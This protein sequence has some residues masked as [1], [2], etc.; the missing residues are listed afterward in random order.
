MVNRLFWSRV[1]LSLQV[2]GA[3]VGAV[4]AVEFEDFPSTAC[5]SVYVYY[6]E[7]KDSQDYKLFEVI[8]PSQFGGEWIFV[9]GQPDEDKFKT[10][11]EIN[12]TS[13]LKRFKFGNDY[14]KYC[15]EFQEEIPVGAQG[16]L[17]KSIGA[18]S[19]VELVK[20]Y[21]SALYKFG[22][23]FIGLICVLVI[24]VSGIQMS[25]GGL[26]SSAFESAKNRILAAILSLVLLFS[27]AMILRTINPGFFT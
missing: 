14:K 25:I 26:D 22:S 23:I 2:F 7:A 27:S 17:S 20:N 18:D 24:V 13:V 10:D 1:L 3:F 15:V 19:G 5:E 8:K 6:F 9:F 11:V 12:S 4:Q 16:E 21:V